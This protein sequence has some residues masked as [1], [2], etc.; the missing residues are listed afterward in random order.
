MNK[1]VTFL[2]ILL[3]FSFLSFAQEDLQ[4][5]KSLKGFERYNGGAL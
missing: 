1:I 5:G 2:F 4:I 3:S